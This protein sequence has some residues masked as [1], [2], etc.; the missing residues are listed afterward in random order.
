MGFLHL[1]LSPQAALAR[2][3]T[4]ET[5]DQL[6]ASLPRETLAKAVGYV[7]LTTVRSL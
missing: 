1:P 3:G 5:G 2:A 7:V 4:P 6:D